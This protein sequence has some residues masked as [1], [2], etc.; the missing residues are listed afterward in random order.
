VY[1]KISEYIPYQSISF[2][3]LVNEEFKEYPF[4]SGTGF[5]VHFPPYDYV[6]YITAKHCFTNISDSE[7]DIDILETLKLPY[8]LNDNA[9]PTDQAILFSEILFG[10][11]KNDDEYEDI[12]VFVVDNN[13][14]EKEKVDLLK[15]RALKLSHQSY[16]N[17][18]LKTLCENNENIRTVGFPTNSKK[19]EYDTN[20]LTIEARGYYGKIKDNSSFR[21]RYG[22]EEA[23]WEEEIYGGFSGSPI[24]ALIPNG[25]EYDVDI[26]V[27]GILL[28]ATSNRGEFLSI[29]FATNLIANYIKANK[30]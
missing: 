19:L 24:L 12:V 1:K 9:K 8:E 27:I 17:Y 26:H 15:K 11:D 29:N 28:T 23:S 25:K 13:K 21:E 30:S 18:I 6:F 3:L 22:F 10:Q 20:L 2:N 7:S 5:F 4:L 16:I 14:I